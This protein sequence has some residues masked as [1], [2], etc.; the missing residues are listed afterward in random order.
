MRSGLG[1]LLHFFGTYDFLRG[2]LGNVSEVHAPLGRLDPVYDCEVFV[3]TV[4]VLR[5]NIGHSFDGLHIF[6]SMFYAQS[7]IDVFQFEEVHVQSGVEYVRKQVA[8]EEV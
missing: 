4:G 5:R 6:S 8:A 7:H 1:S 3:G 2:P